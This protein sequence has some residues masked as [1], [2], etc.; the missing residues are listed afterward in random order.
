MHHLLRT[1]AALATSA[2]VTTMLA[3]PAFAGPD[4]RGGEWLHSQQRDDGLVENEQFDLVDY[5]LTADFGLAFAAIGRRAAALALVREGLADNVEGYTGTGGEVY[6]GPTAKLLV[7][8]QKSGGGATDFGGFDLVRRLSGRVVKRGPA[9]G[10]IKDKGAFDYANTIGQAFAV[11]GLGRARAARRRDAMQFL[12]EQ[13]CSPGF[14]RL[15]FS[16]PAKRDQGCNAARARNRAPDTDATALAVLNLMELPRGQK[17]RRVKSA[18]DEAS[19]WLRRAQ[20]KNGSFGG[21]VSTE[22]SNSNSTG[23]AAWALGTTG[24]CRPARRAAGWV[25]DLQL[26][27]DLTGTPVEGEKGAIAY[28]RAG[29]REGRD[30]IEKTERDQW[31][32]AT[33]QAAPGLA[34]LRSRACR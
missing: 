6:A 5:G 14:F 28:D 24:S 12:L 27:G 17:T 23:L 2:V 26:A 9:T 34:Y 10:R 31:R 29:Y 18:I 20:K 33:S 13:Q 3:A 32:R 1:V 19:R 11:R 7:L 21:G 25:R 30:G 8:V 22:G 15:D 4:D 16:A